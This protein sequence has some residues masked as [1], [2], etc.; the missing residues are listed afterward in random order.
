MTQVNI[1]EAAV[2]E[3][4]G[5]PCSPQRARNPAWE[6]MYEGLMP[7]KLCI[8]RGGGAVL[9]KDPKDSAARGNKPRA[10]GPSEGAVWW[11][12]VTPE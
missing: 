8:M 5:S 11:L 10:L 6:Q 12:D 4:R 9:S 3:D 1:C 7:S 2:G